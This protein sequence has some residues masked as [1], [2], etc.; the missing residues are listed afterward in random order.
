MFT[1]KNGPGPDDATREQDGSLLGDQ[2]NVTGREYP[3]GG[4]IDE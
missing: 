1:I 3:F 4:K 2:Y